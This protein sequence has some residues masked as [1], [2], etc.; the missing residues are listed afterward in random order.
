M[1]NLNNVGDCLKAKDSN[2]EIDACFDNNRLAR[3]F[4]NQIFQYREFVWLIRNIDCQIIVNYK[5]YL[6]RQCQIV[7]IKLILQSTFFIFITQ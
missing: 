5:A 3:F 2:S 1:K 7:I 6:I 4:Q